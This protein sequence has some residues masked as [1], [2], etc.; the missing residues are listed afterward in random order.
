MTP[1]NNA[2][3]SRKVKFDIQNLHSRSAPH[4]DAKSTK[5]KATEVMYQRAKSE[6][7]FKWLEELHSDGLE[8]SS[9]SY[10]IRRARGKILNEINFVIQKKTNARIAVAVRLIDEY[11]PEIKIEY[12]ALQLRKIAMGSRK[13]QCER[14]MRTLLP[15]LEARALDGQFSLFIRMSLEFGST[16]VHLEPTL[17]SGEVWY[18]DQNLLDA[19]KER[20][21]KLS[22]DRKRH[23]AKISF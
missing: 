10:A 22:V 16:G 13:D 1:T 2:K 6:K 11:L 14:F 15:L 23:V 12:T 3:E 9:W 17:R 7:Y 20:G 4:A 5:L 19:L 21:L 8:R 18:Y